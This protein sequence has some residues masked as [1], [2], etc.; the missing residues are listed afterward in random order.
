MDAVTPCGACAGSGF[1]SGCRGDGL[2]LAAFTVNLCRV[3]KGDGI[4]RRARPRRWCPACDG[5]GRYLMYNELVPCQ[6]CIGDG[7]CVPCAG[8][9]ELPVTE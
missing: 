6:D 8:S 1:C 5:S 2:V 3:C 7:A 4:L 9:G